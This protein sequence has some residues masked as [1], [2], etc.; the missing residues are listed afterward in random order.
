MEDIDHLFL[1]CDFFTHLW[2]DISNWFDFITVP[3]EHV[4]YHFLQFENLEFS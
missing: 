1:S 2:H 4:S 3:P